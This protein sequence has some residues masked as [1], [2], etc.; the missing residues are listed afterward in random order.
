MLYWMQHPAPFLRWKYLLILF[1]HSYSFYLFLS[2]YS[3]ELE[4][5]ET[6]AQKRKRSISY[7]FVLL[8][9]T[10]SIVILNSGGPVIRLKSPEREDARSSRSGRFAAAGVSSK[11]EAVF[12][13]RKILLFKFGYQ[14]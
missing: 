4:S 6:F 3:F 2:L 9:L 8:R 10:S 14:N 13:R 5:Q 7:A 11:S 1:S 12:L